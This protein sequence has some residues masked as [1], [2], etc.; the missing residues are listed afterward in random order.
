MTT[1][2]ERIEEII[3]ESTCC[4]E[5]WVRAEEEFGDGGVNYLLSI[6]Y[7]EED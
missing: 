6:G 2:K 1:L 7:P 3:E 4:E 5:V